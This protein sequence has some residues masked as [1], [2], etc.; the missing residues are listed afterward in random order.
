MEVK[1]IMEQQFQEHGS[2]NAAALL[3]ASEPDTALHG[4]LSSLLAGDSL[5]ADDQ[6]SAHELRLVV[7]QARIELAGEHMRAHQSAPDSDAYRDALRQLT[8]LRQQ[9]E[10]LRRA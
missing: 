2:Q 8:G 10:T 6:T 1:D 7:T 4:S 5:A 3:R 9:L